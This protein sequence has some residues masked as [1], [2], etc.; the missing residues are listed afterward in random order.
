MMIFKGMVNATDM[1][2]LTPIIVSATI[3]MRGAIDPVSSQ[4]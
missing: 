2:K 1:A 4:F 3:F